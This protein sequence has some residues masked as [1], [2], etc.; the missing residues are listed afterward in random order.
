[1]GSS[2]RMPSREALQGRRFQ[3]RGPRHPT[4][5]RARFA[6]DNR[7][8]GHNSVPGMARPDPSQ[9]LL[10]PE[11]RKSYWLQAQ[12]ARCGPIGAGPPCLLGSPTDMSETKNGR[13]RRARRRAYRA[14]EIPL[15]PRG[16]ALRCTSAESMYVKS[17][18]LPYSHTLLPSVVGLASISTCGYELS[19]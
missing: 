2:V 4:L 15:R 12:A 16:P 8:A 19:M 6:G 3:G 1:M 17:P 18:N 14:Y 13:A 10:R 7:S 9:R 11:A 5:A